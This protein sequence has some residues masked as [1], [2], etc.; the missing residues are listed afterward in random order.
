MAN[1]VFN[2]SKDIRVQF[3][4][5]DASAFILGLSKLNGVQTL[6]SSTAATWTD[7]VTDVVQ[8]E[9]DRGTAMENG[10]Y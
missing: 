4:V 2:I 3:E 7:V 8:V 6:G 1:D 5:T 9:I 10:I